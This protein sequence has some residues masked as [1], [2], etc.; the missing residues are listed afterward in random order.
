MQVKDLPNLA[1][2]FDAMGFDNGSNVNPNADIPIEWTDRCF[3]A[4]SE[5]AM[6]TMGEIETLAM[7]E[8]TEQIAVADKAPTAHVVLNAAFDDGPLADIVFTEWRGV[9]DAV[10]AEQA[11]N[12]KYRS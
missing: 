3:T 8:E 1:K 12:K 10:A 7:G 4:D 9:D 2:A 11:Y 5:L 6:L